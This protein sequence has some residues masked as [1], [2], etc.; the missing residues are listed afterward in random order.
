MDHLPMDPS[1]SAIL[2]EEMEIG[3]E[4]FPS[5]L[6]G[7]SYDMLVVEFFRGPGPGANGPWG[8]PA[9]PYIKSGRNREPRLLANCR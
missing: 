2:Y 7:R 3:G 9:E 5:A 4:A 6:H 8:G 1:F